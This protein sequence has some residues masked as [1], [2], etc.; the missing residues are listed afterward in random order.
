[1]NEDWRAVTKFPGYEVN[2]LGVVREVGGDPLKVY[3]RKDGMRFVVFPGK[4]QRS[5]ERLVRDAFGGS[6][7][8][9]CL[10]CLR[11]LHETKGLCF[12]LPRPDII[13]IN[14]PM[15]SALLRKQYES[16]RIAVDSYL[17]AL[18]EQ[19]MEHDTPRQK[20]VNE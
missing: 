8:S 13:F 16:T 15:A 10:K 1:M 11:V 7:T 18:I 20:A 4:V 17:H 12:H 3:E 14:N 2:H 19:V 9:D 6:S 5:I